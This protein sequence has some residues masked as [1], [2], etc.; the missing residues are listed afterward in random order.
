MTYTIHALS[1][2]TARICHGRTTTTSREVAS[3]VEAHY[4]EQGFVTNTVLEG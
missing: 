1:N 3:M 4:R 2:D